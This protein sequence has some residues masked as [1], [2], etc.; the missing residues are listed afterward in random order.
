MLIFKITINISGDNLK[1]NKIFSLIEG[2]CII[3]S[4]YEKGDKILKNS[5]RIYEFGV[6]SFWHPKKFGKQGEGIGYEKWFV[7]FIEQNYNIFIEY[8]CEDISLYIEV[9]NIINEQC[10]F[11][12]FNKEMLKTLCNYN[13][14]LPISIYQLNESEFNEFILEID[15]RENQ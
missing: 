6:I 7:D 2:N 1:P 13:V 3:A 5:K 9:Y 14:S 4:S 12:I 8:G 11:E 10:N 15:K